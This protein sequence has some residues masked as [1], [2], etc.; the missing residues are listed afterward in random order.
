MASLNLRASAHAAIVRL[1]KEIQNADFN[2]DNVECEVLLSPVNQHFDRFI[3]HHFDLVSKAKENEIASH[4]EL[5]ATT[6]SLYTTLCVT[7]QRR[8]NPQTAVQV[9]SSTINHVADMRLDPVSIPRF[10]GKPTSWLAFKDLFEPMVHNRTDLDPAYKLG[11]LRQCVDQESVPMIGGLYTGGYHEVW[12]ELK[13]RYDNPRL[14]AETHVQIFLD[15]PNNPPEASNTLRSIV[16]CVCNSFRAL[17]VMDIPVHH[18][19]SIAVP[20]LLP[21]LP[22]TTRN[23]WGM[24]LTSVSISKLEDLLLFLERRANHITVAPQTV[25]TQPLFRRFASRTVKAH[26]GATNNTQCTT[27]PPRQCWLPSVLR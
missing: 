17:A 21:K 18:W 8:L 15:L 9:A 12:S 27:A 23:E 10:D 5:F 26:V 7:L 6:E 2:P 13:R 14:L 25:S 11:K 22:T 19:D 16:D 1:G 3:H 24:S 4:E 20:V